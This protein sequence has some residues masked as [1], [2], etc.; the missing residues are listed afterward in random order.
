MKTHTIHTNNR[1]TNYLT[2]AVSAGTLASTAS[3][4]VVSLDV[5]SISGP[6]GGVS[7]GGNS[8]VPLSTLGVDLTGYI[9]IYNRPSSYMGLSVGIAANGPY[10][11]PWNFAGGA[12]IDA[13]ASFV[14]YTPQTVFT[15]PLTNSISPD[16]GPNSFIG[17]RSD[18]NH[19]GYLEVTWTSATNTFEILSGAYESTPGVGIRAGAAAIPEPSTAM[20]SLGALAAGAFIRRRKQAA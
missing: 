14:S 3:A 2:T 10:A 19:Y 17:F 6:N 4:A 11:S 18:N 1:L 8:L 20:L 15:D 13:A 12:M 5:S 16:F 9:L 7:S